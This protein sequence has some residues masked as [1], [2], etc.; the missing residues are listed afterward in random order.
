MTSQRSQAHH[1]SHDIWPL[2][3]C[4]SDAHIVVGAAQGGGT[5]VLSC[6]TNSAC[7]NQLCSQTPPWRHCGALCRAPEKVFGLLDC[8]ENLDAILP[9]LNDILAGAC[10]NL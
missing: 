2:T 3:N 5:N 9:V 6:C 8:H 7:L 4:P 10:S 1:A